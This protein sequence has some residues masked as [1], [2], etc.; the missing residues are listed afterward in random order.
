MDEERLRLHPHVPGRGGVQDEGDVVKV[1]V[2]DAAGSTGAMF[3]YR[4]VP[5]PDREGNWNSLRESR[6]LYERI[7]ILSEFAQ[8]SYA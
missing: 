2:L 1:V 8:L 3:K 5:L 6:N 7:L 4:E